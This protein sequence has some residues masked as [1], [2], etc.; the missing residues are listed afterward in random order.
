MKK[1]LAVLVS[2]AA[3]GAGGAPLRAAWIWV[4][5]EKPAVNKMNRHPWYDQVKRAELS[6]GD[7]LSNFHPEKIGE[8]EYRFEAPIAGEYEFW[9][10]ANPVQASLVYQLNG[11]EEKEV[12]FKGE[13]RGQINL[14]ADGK[15]D[16]RFLAWV[17]AGPATLKAGANTLRFRTTSKNSHHGMIDCF[18]LSNEPFRP[19]GVLKPDQLAKAQTQWSAIHQGWL[20]FDPP[21]D[22]FAASP[23]D[24]R[25]LNEPVAGQHGF[26]R[27]QDGQFLLGNGEPVRFWGVNG[28]PH[29]LKDRAAIRRAARLLAK[30]GVNLVRAHGA[31]FDKRGEANLEA[32]KHL[33][34]VVEEMKAEG[35]YT[36]LSIYFPLWFAPPPD[37]A[38]LPGYDGKKHPFA[39]LMFNRQF[40]AKYQDWLK[41]LL[42]T[43]G[44]KSGR[45]LVDEPAVFGLEIQNEDSFLFWTFSADNL[46]DPQLRQ[47]EKMFGDWLIRRHGSLDAALARWNGQKTRRDAPAEGR[48]GF[49]PLWNMVNEKTAR[50]RDTVRFLVELQTRF[51]RESYQFLRQLGFRALISASNWTTASAEVLGPLEAWSYTAGDFADRHGYFGC[52]HKGDNAAWSIREG[53]TYADRSALRFDAET[54]GQPKQFLHPVMD[55]EY[56]GKPTMISETTFNRPNRYRTEAPLYF[57]A[58]AALQGSDALV[59]FALDGADW[60]VKPN[61]FMQPWTLM[62][63]AMM[64]QFPAAALLYR[65]GLVAAGRVLAD[66]RLNQEDLL[67]LQG[68]PLPLG[69]SFDELRL[70]DVPAGVEFKPGQRIDPLLHYAGRARVQFVAEPAEVQRQDLR[71]YVDHARQTVSSS[72][73]ELKLDYGRGLLTVNAPQ[74]QG[75]CGN[76]Q[77]A[78]R[79]ELRDVIF[80]SP[81]ELAAMLA[82][83]LDGQPLAGSEKILLQVMSEEQTAGF[84]TEPS[85][86]GKKIVNLGRDPWLFKEIQGTV[87]FKRPDAARL[88][89]TPLDFNG[90][91]QPDT[92]PANGPEIRLAAGVFYYLITSQ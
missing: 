74:A 43:P 12:D 20:P 5:G 47:L 57:A 36:H 40:Q 76:L 44:E 22:P 62:S 82:V 11:G 86:Q 15:P 25:F 60:E 42:L 46:P 53:H 31:I 34:T 38:W 14:A 65:R 17:K 69:A 64:G 89:V 78:G 23:M 3:L 41:A 61:F 19:Q 88:K 83:A 66:L 58:Y 37:L 16:L 79:A 92:A 71:P 50:D 4:E 72:T 48:L 73:G 26:V 30:R 21:P 1:T 84:Q 81:L 67:N 6:G 85:G 77:A 18:V 75:L 51:Y 90:Y 55:I 7:F 13:K 24:L 49:R 68:T 87:R 2:L 10:R 80:S 63:P 29:E 28:P 52:L 56:Q 59:H 39:A 8:A 70:R 91:P 33:L 9:I 35:I 54:P 45:R 32:V 27:A